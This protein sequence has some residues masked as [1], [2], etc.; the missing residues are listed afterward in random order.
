MRKKLLFRNCLKTEALFSDFFRT[1]V[2]TLAS[3][4]AG[5]QE[6]PASGDTLIKLSR[7][8]ILPV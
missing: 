2:Q 6:Y 3:D 5:K 8:L 1:N 4:Q 7:G